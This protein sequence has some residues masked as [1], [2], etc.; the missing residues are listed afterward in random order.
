M[1]CIPPKQNGEFVARM[2][3]LLDLYE[4]PPDPKRPKVCFDEQPYQIVA[5][6]RQA[7]PGR[8]GRPA[9]VDYE[10]RRTG[11]A[12][13]FMSFDPDRG[14]RHVSIT[15]RRTKR[16]FAYELR[17]LVDEDYP[18]ADVLRLVTDNLNTHT[19][20]A[21][22]ET[23]PPAEARRIAKKEAGVPLHAQARQLAQ[24][25]RDR[26]LGPQ[27]PVP[28]SAPG[29]SGHPRTRGRRLASGAQPGTLHHR[30]AV[31]QRRRQDQT[32]SRLS[33]RFIVATY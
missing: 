20:A 10:Y 18:D 33:R 15:D 25:G 12:N 22:Y 26:T 4:E 6:T 29:R 2:E 5:E 16:D 28:R 31:H 13:L 7:L 24:H 30:V 17:R 1:W 21:L 19:T 11:T 3:D 27:R 8:P 14:W 23:F 32:A 9:R